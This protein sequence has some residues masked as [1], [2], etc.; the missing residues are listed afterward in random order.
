MIISPS[1]SNWKALALAMICLAYSAGAADAPKTMKITIQ[2]DKQ[3][4]RFVL[5]EYAVAPGQ[6]APPFAMKDAESNAPVPCQTEQTAGGAVVRWLIPELATNKPAWFI[7]EHADAAPKPT[8]RVEDNP[9]GYLS[10]RDADHEITRYYFRPAHKAHQKPYFYP[11][12]VQGVPITRSYPM[13]KKAGED[14]DHPHHTSIYF[15]E[16]EVNGTDYWSTAPI[17]H[18]RFIEKSSGPV[19]GHIVAENE[20]GKDI[21]ETQDVIIFE[22]GGDVLMDWAITLTAANGP[23]VFGKTKEGGFS[24]RVAQGIVDKSGGKMIDADGNQGEPAIRKHAA[25]WAD[26]YGT[27]DGK[28]VGVA[29]MN[30]PKSW[31][32]P[33]DWHVRGYGLFTANAFFVQGEHKLAKGDSITLRYRLYFHGGD[34]KEAKVSE[35]YAGYAKAE[36]KAE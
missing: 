33:T 20:W 3:D 4:R 26:D 34:P 35:V 11:L 22:S 27:V 19:F 12:I 18:K 25:V 23:V 31:R 21:S 9:S 15:A 24:V 30:H 16:G 36:V 28:L 5:A 29:I 32:F 2:P 17:I 6:L 8:I 7:L 1:R 10:I 14:T 13:E